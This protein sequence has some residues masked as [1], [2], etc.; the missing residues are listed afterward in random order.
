MQ[1][2]PK[3]HFSVSGASWVNT[4][5]HTLIIINFKL[6]SNGENNSN[7][8]LHVSHSFSSLKLHVN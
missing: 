6:N 5:L 7:K 1:D 8:Q 2:L 4:S 3:N